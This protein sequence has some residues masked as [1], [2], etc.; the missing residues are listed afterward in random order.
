MSLALVGAGYLVGIVVGLA[1]FVGV[2]L[3]WGVA[4]PIL[5][6]YLIRRPDGHGLSRTCRRGSVHGQTSG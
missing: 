1:M 6:A 3:A 2:L 5:V 4:V